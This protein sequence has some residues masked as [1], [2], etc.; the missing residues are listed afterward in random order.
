VAFN[1]VPCVCGCK[2]GKCADPNNPRSWCFTISGVHATVPP[3]T[4]WGDC[5]GCPAYNG[6]WC[7]TGGCSA[8]SAFNSTVFEGGPFGVCDWGVSIDGHDP[9]GYF[10]THPDADQSMWEMWYDPTT[11]G[12]WLSAHGIYDSPILY[13]P[14]LDADWN[15]NGPNTFL[16]HDRP[17]LCPGFPDS[18][19]VTACICGDSSSSSGGGCG[20]CTYTYSALEVAWII[21]NDF[22]C[23]ASCG[24]GAPPDLTGLEVDGETV[25]VACMLA[26]CPGDCVFTW[27]GA[28]WHASDT[29]GAGCECST[30]PYSGTFVGETA[31]VP[32]KAA[33]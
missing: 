16:V 28:V 17:S 32:C 30:V 33:P 7:I 31:I 3:Y 29:C 24:C 11:P 6:D 25:T 21:T 14:I 5:D 12:W 13:G 2:C 23:G 15:C 1:C 10:A 20:T 18:I 27:D 26:A 22:S 19:T 8:S 9:C 4:G